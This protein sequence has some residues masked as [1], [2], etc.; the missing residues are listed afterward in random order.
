MYLYIPRKE[1]LHSEDIGS[2]VSYGIQVRDETGKV[3]TNVPDVSTNE[4]F[5]REQCAKFTQHQLEPIHLA[6]V[7]EDIL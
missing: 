3:Y 6:D 2:Y 4:T 1:S 5:V 7:L